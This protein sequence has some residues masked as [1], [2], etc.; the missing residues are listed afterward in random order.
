M[1][2]AIKK[3]MAAAEELGHVTDMDVLDFGDNRKMAFFEGNTEEGTHFE[4]ELRIGIVPEETE[5]EK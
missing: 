3:A 4:L 2:D 1:I 5:D